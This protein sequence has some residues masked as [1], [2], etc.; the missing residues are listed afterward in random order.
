MGWNWNGK[1]LAAPGKGC[2]IEFDAYLIDGDRRVPCAEG[3]TADPGNVGELED[4]F[5]T[6]LEIA[7]LQNL[8]R[9]KRAR[10]KIGRKRGHRFSVSAD[11]PEKLAKSL[12]QM[13]G[14]VFL[15]VAADVLPLAF[16]AEEALRSLSSLSSS[17][18]PSREVISSSNVCLRP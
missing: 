16:F 12:P 17:S 14:M 5:V 7:G 1:K 2:E 10:I 13:K 9:S 15:E 6:A 8:K 18:S 3:L 11:L 4:C